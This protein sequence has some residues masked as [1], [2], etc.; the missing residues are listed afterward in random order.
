[1]KVAPLF[2]YQSGLANG[3]TITVDS[4]A[5]PIP[6]SMKTVVSRR[7]VAD[8]QS[9]GL[10]SPSWNCNDCILSQSLS[11]LCFLL[12]KLPFYFQ[13]FLPLQYLYY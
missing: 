11:N 7:S 3:C 2:A 8:F 9:N 4:T 5:E 6:S 13:P 12:A 10:P 1:M